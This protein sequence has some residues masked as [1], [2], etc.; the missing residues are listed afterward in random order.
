MGITA[1]IGVLIAEPKPAPVQTPL[2]AAPGPVL[3]TPSAPSNSSGSSSGLLSHPDEQF[4]QGPSQ[5]GWQQPDQS[6]LQPR[7]PGPGPGFQPRA[8]GFRPRF[9]ESQQQQQPRPRF[10]APGPG[11]FRPQLNRSSSTFENSR[12][13]GPPDN[14][15]QPPPLAGAR[16]HGPNQSPRFVAPLEETRQAHNYPATR[17]APFDEPRGPRDFPGPRSSGPY[18]EPRGP[19][20]FPG[21]R[22]SGPYEEP[23]GPR[24]FPGPRTSRPY[25]EPRG[26]RDFSG[27]RSSAP[28]EE[29]RGPQDFPG[30]RFSAPFEEP[31]RPSDFPGSRASV[32]FEEPKRPQDFPGPRAASAFDRQMQPSGSQGLWQ[33]GGPAPR[34]SPFEGP[35]SISRGTNQPLS[36][37]G[38]NQSAPLDGPA[39]FEGPR[40]SHFVPDR[41]AWGQRPDNGGPSMASQASKRPHFSAEEPTSAKVL[42]SSQP[43]PG[44]GPQS[45]NPAGNPD[46]EALMQHL[47]FYQSQMS[48]EL[49]RRN[50]Q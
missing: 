25:E 47:A 29:S 10:D 45:E 22:S 41:A 38:S 3:R 21:P 43:A 4:L 32:S 50:L 15:R 48:A 11:S 9:P 2:P 28:Y 16:S 26:P 34:P 46:Y 7:H 1:P 18:Q 42:K 30:R 24:D 49:Q 17:P 23:R 27:P 5:P 19:R 37:E 44:T 36:R 6:R 8:E 33:P 40:S 35:A 31:R 13:S 20:D 14:A 12:P 39:T